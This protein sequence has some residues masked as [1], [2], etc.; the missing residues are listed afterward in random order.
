MPI[1]TK[2]ETKRNQILQAA[3]EV[4]TRF[5]YDK[6]T[7]D[8]IGKKCQLNKASLYYYFKNKEEIFI[9]VILIESTD[10]IQNLQEQT[11]AL[12]TVQQKVI[13]YLTERVKR[14]QEV[15]NGNQLSLE[16]LQKI[17]PLWL[18]TYQ[19]VKA[20][21]I[22]YLSTLLREI[23]PDGLPNWTY[24]ELAESLFLISDALKHDRM[25][26]KEI[27]FEGKYDYSKI[28]IRLGKLVETI[29]KGLS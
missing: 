10:F 7:L 12:E 21:E 9:E 15:I 20:R 14:Y 22:D 6:T 1:S 11:S 5:G 16:S 25:I 17:E 27:Y 8:D 2:K 29:F 3:K 24:Q 4:F 19:S 18:K 13:H 23:F 28:K 26:Q